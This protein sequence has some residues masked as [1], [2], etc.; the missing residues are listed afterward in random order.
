MSAI[1]QYKAA[2]Y[3]KS[4]AWE[5]ERFIDGDHVII[6]IYGI[7]AKPCEFSA[8]RAHGVWT[9]NNT[10]E[11]FGTLSRWGRTRI[12]RTYNP[13]KSNTFLKVGNTYTRVCNLQPQN[14]HR[15]TL[16]EI[17][18]KLQAAIAS[19]AAAR[20]EEIRNA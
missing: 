13:K 12:T 19:R 11:Q 10:N 2:N 16:Q 1:E 17:R 3:Q 14:D 4:L 18:I 6:Y 7:S 5:A 9:D 20:A 15:D 8:T